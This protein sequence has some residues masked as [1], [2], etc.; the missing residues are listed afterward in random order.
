MGIQ[1]A[2]FLF[3]DPGTGHKD[4]FSFLEINS[5]AHL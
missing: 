3:P 2:G 5:T 1:S 4:L